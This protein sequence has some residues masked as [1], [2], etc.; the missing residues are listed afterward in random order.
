MLSKTKPTTKSLCPSKPWLRLHID[1][2][3]PTNGQYFFVVVD[4]YTKW[5]EVIPIK[6]VHSDVKTIL[7]KFGYPLIILNVVSD[8][9]TIT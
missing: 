5:V 2:A 8:N 3:G 4:A 1:F 9:T 7:T 6:L